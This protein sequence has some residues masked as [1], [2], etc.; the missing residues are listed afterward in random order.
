MISLFLIFIMMIAAG[1]GTRNTKSI[2]HGEMQEL[3]LQ[4]MQNGCAKLFQKM[5]EIVA[6]IRLDDLTMQAA[7]RFTRRL[8]KTIQAT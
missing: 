6:E 8:H 2:S 7:I 1:Y 3:K 4:E 5:Q